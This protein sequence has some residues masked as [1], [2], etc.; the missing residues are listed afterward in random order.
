M[1]C[2]RAFTSL[3]A[4][5]TITEAPMP[6]DLPMLSPP[7]NTVCLESF[8]ALAL[9]K[10]LSAFSAAF[11]A[12]VLTSLPLTTVTMLA[13]MPLAPPAATPA[14]PATRVWRTLAST[15]TPL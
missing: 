11:E 9:I 2:A 14:A 1:S 5:F 8:W 4:T 12:S 10:P 7:A 15:Y 13:V 6:M 3:R